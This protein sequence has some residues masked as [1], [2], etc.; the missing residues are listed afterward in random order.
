MNLILKSEPESA[1]QSLERLKRSF[2]KKES[3]PGKESTQSLEKREPKVCE[4]VN[5]EAGG[6]EWI[7]LL[8]E[9]SEPESGK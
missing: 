2:K 3:E 9:K 5:P 8:S 7:G 6:K 4:R 1:K